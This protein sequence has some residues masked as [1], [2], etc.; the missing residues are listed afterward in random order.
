MFLNLSTLFVEDFTTRA[1]DVPTESYND[2]YGEIELQNNKEM[3]SY[4][5]FLV[6]IECILLV[7]IC[8]GN[9]L[10]CGAFV[11]QKKLRTISNCYILQLAVAD[12]LVGLTRPLSGLT[13][14]MPS[15]LRNRGLCAF[16]YT[17]TIFPMCASVNALTLLTVDRYIAT[18]R[19]LTYTGK[20]A[21]KRS[22]A[23]SFLIWIPTFL[24]GFLLPQVLHADLT[25]EQDG[26]K[27]DE[28]WHGC[29]LLRVMKPEIL[30]Y[31]IGNFFIFDTLI[32]AV[33]YGRIFVIAR[34]HARS[35]SAHLP[36]RPSRNMSV[37]STIQV[38]SPSKMNV[39]L[40]G[41]NSK[42][43]DKALEKPCG[44]QGRRFSIAKSNNS[45]LFRIQLKMAKT[46]SLILGTFYICWLPF[47]ILLLIQ[48]YGHLNSTS[49][50]T[51]RSFTTFL[52]LFNSG[53]NPIIYAYRMS[54]IR[55]EFARI[56]RFFKL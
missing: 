5:I 10:I 30:M 8:G 38:E 4:S 37:P 31:T 36:V 7:L 32:I 35:I 40:E 48:F 1:R 26:A 42:Q 15:L 39:H 50:S 17:S 41:N 27:R 16:V 45:N 43:Q 3:N 34:Q 2:M 54:P 56:L 53:I 21:I 52:A 24:V 33:L 14:I 47:Y 6:C 12:L 46:G 11:R 13:W 18:T 29:L 28:P 19:P 22:L 51:A 44:N 23:A 20:L 25:Q 9:A 55:K 49:L